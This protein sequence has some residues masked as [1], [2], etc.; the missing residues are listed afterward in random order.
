M[1]EEKN[2]R[3][4]QTLKLGENKSQD[5]ST[6]TLS[7]KDFDFLQNMQ[8]LETDSFLHDFYNDYYEDENKKPPKIV[9]FLGADKL[10]IQNYVGMIKLPD[11]GIL[12][13][14][15]KVQI[16]PDEKNW[17]REE[18]YRD[19]KQVL[20]D[21]IVS[22]LAPKVSKEMDADD[23]EKSL[24]DYIIWW[25]LHKID[26]LLKYGV[27]QDYVL[28]DENSSFVKGKIL[29]S[30]NI[31][32]NSA[33]QHRT[34][35]EYEDFTPDCIENRILHSALLACVK[36]AQNPKI[37]QDAV[38]FCH[39]FDGIGEMTSMNDFKQWT[40][41]RFYKHYTD[42]KPLAEIILTGV[43]P[44][45]TKGKKS[46][47]A[48]LFPM[49]MVFEKYIAQCLQDNAGDYKVRTQSNTEQLTDEGFTL[50]PD[51]V[52]KKNGENIAVLDT[53][54]KPYKD[55]YIST[56]D[57]Y[58]MYAYSQAYGKV[59]TILLYPK[60]HSGEKQGK[61][62]KN[63]FKH[64]YDNDKKRLKTHL[65]DLSQSPEKIAEDIRA[66]IP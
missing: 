28:V 57:A 6:F 47:P 49:E 16:V 37:K 17:D 64:G 20:I 7:K 52:L 51:I 29:F 58:Q 36:H 2:V 53:K 22:T 9:R 43:Q 5:G 46:I 35:I 26:D 19:E 44:F 45:M 1:S 39:F 13:I 38:R 8:D 3:E 24:M 11:A 66:E 65:I 14:L 10:R 62:W 61:P 23:D 60:N 40:D 34:Y 41:N 30:Q 48:I 54:W 63:H 56:A 21:M 15:P 32:Y 31:R 50:R 42:I 25:F 12:E 18:K 33:L 55:K 4:F 27:K 59:D